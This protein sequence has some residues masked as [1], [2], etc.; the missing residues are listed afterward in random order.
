MSVSTEHNSKGN[1]VVP[2]PQPP[3]ANFQPSAED[4]ARLIRAFVSIRSSERRQAVL[5]F[6]FEQARMEKPLPT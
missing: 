4:G 1:F 5:E 3:S 6:V 2:A